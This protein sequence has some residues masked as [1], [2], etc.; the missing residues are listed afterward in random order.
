[1]NKAKSLGIAAM[2]LA[3]VLVLLQPSQAGQGEE[4]LAKAIADYLVAARGV[5]ARNQTLINDSAKGDKGF[6]PAVFEGQ[7]TEE[8][9]KVGGIDL[10]TATNSSPTGKAL[11]ELNDAAKEVI[12]DAQP[13]INEQGKAFKGFTPAIFGARTGDKFYKKTKLKLKQTS[14]KFRGDYNRPDDFEEEVLKKFEAKW[15]KGKP[16]MEETTLGGRKVV[17][18]M[19]PL[20]IATSCLTCHGDPAGEMDISGRIKE[21]YKEGDLRGAISVIV[22]VK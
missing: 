14:L 9:K 18:Y 10:K 17:R 2:G 11:L 4:G 5:I 15:D 21:G 12:A 1:M 13:E 3:A 8:F 19:K 22:P 16:Y 7:V 6:T 20:Y